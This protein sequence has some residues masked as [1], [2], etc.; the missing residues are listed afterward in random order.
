MHII[1]RQQNRELEGLLIGFDEYVNLVLENVTEFESE[2]DGTVVKV[3]LPNTRL[4]LNGSNIC[5]LV[6][7]GLSE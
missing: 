1:M 4:L 7:G 3:K 6:P 2:E 5:M